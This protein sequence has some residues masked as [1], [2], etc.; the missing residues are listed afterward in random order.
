MKKAFAETI[1]LAVAASSPS[2][3]Q[4]KPTGAPASAAMLAD[5]V[6]ATGGASNI[7]SPLQGFG[8]AEI[9]SPDGKKHFIW[10]PVRPYG[11]TMYLPFYRSEADIRRMGHEALNIDVDKVQSIKVSGLYQEHMVV[12]GRRKHLIATRLVEGPVELFNY[13]GTMQSTTSGIL[14]TVA[15]GAVGVGGVGGIPERHWFLRR[16]GGELIS[17]KRDG[18]SAQM[19]AYFHD[20]PVLATAFNNQQLDYADM[21][22]I[23][24]DYNAFC[25]QA[26][27]K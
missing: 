16:V 6:A 20:D 26:A 7:N 4:Q 17:V 8:R 12:N 10:I 14:L 9:L 27:T 11:F 13:T 22:K 1:L 15:A 3:A 19:S 2:F 25:A 21:V 23:V 24:Q 18:F 5:T